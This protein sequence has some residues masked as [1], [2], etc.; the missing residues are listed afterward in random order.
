MSIS[1]SIHAPLSLP[2]SLPSRLVHTYIHVTLCLLL[3]EYCPAW[4]DDM[5][6]HCGLLMRH[7]C[8]PLHHAALAHTLHNLGPQLADHGHYPIQLTLLTY[9]TLPAFISTGVPSS[10]PCHGL[11]R[12]DVATRCDKWC[13]G[14][15]SLPPHWPRPPRTGPLHGRPAFP[16]QW[17]PR[18]HHP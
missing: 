10:C 12:H 18:H 16:S 4:V 7:D 15:L 9:S 11:P 13:A 5:P 2:H 14:C 8:N 17:R 6:V 1:L 3:L